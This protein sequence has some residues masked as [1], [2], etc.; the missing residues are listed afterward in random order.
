MTG[1]PR[2]RAEMCEG[3]Q[4]ADAA[5]RRSSQQG[6]IHM[7]ACSS[8][9]LWVAVKRNTVRP[10]ENDL[11]MLAPAQRYAVNRRGCTLPLI[12]SRWLPK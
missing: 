10:I 3:S 9:L 2:R 11:N 1:R 7:E 5:L 8:E 12:T 6:W 4:P